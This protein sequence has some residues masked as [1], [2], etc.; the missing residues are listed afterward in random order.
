MRKPHRV[1]PCPHRHQPRHPL[2]RR[3]QRLPGL[4]RP[5]RRHQQD[6]RQHSDR[7]AVAVDLIHEGD[8]GRR[9]A[10]AQVVQGDLGNSITHRT[11]ALAV[12]LQRLVPTMYLMVGGLIVAVILAVPAGV[13]A[14]G[15]F[16]VVEAGALVCAGGAAAGAAN[17][18]ATFNF[19]SAAGDLSSVKFASIEPV[20]KPSCSASIL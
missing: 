19:N 10:V 20:S 17:D 4:P 6:R 13:L 1:A 8:F 15:A 18:A 16:A 14:A 11:P 5:R 9:Q 2:R 7:F 3:G 12:I